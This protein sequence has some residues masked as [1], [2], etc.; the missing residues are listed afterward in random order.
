MPSVEKKGPVKLDVDSRSDR[1]R[2]G[3]LFWSAAADFAEAYAHEYNDQLGQ[4]GHEECFP[5]SRGKGEDDFVF[6][7][8]N[9]HFIGLSQ[10]D[11]DEKSNIKS[12][13][14]AVGREVCL[15]GRSMDSAV[16]AFGKLPENLKFA[17][18]DYTTDE[19]H[20]D[21]LKSEGLSGVKSAD[22]SDYMPPGTSR[23]ER[24]TVGELIERLENDLPED[25]KQGLE[26]REANHR[27]DYGNDMVFLH[28]MIDAVYRECLDGTTSGM[29]AALRV[30]SQT[31]FD[32][33]FAG[34]YVAG[35]LQDL[36]VQRGAEDKFAVFAEHCDK[37]MNE[38][39][40]GKLEEAVKNVF[41]KITGSEGVTVAPSPHGNP[42]GSGLAGEKLEKIG[43]VKLED[44]Y[45]KAI[46]IKASDLVSEH[47]SIAI[48]AS[49]FKGKE[50]DDAEFQKSNEKFLNDKVGMSGLENYVSHAAFEV[51]V[52]GRYLDSAV[53]AFS[54]LPKSCKQDIVYYVSKDSTVLFQAAVEKIASVST[55]RDAK[56]RG[57]NW[58]PDASIMRFNNQS[59]SADMLKAGKDVE[60]R[61]EAMAAYI[62]HFGVDVGVSGC[63]LKSAASV[64]SDLPQD[65]KKEVTDFLKT[66]ILKLDNKYFV[67]DP[68]PQRGGKD[69]T[70]ENI[71]TAKIPKGAF[72]IPGSLP[73]LTDVRGAAAGEA[74]KKDMA[75][76]AVVAEDWGESWRN[77]IATDIAVMGY[78]NEKNMMSHDKAGKDGFSVEDVP[79]VLGENPEC[80]RQVFG[81]GGSVAVMEQRPERN[82]E[83]DLNGKPE[84]FLIKTA[85]GAS[86][87]TED[88][89]VGKHENLSC[90]VKL[91]AIYENGELKMDKD[92]KVV[93]EGKLENGR[94]VRVTIEVESGIEKFAKPDDAIKRAKEVLADDLYKSVALGKH[95]ELLQAKE[96]VAKAAE[97]GKA[98]NT[99]KNDITD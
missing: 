34:S 35:E 96:N 77:K 44:I 83:I 9:N 81:A 16:E 25:W 98:D 84:Y 49:K 86:G 10:V 4:E 41:E 14:E 76:S 28:H 39:S 61:K 24:D 12:Y 63:S 85:F 93:F 18:M 29:D 74:L 26:S 38:L 22:T 6:K 30:L 1:E 21:V 94:Q 31:S 20:L 87:K 15:H 58:E 2:E 23:R 52:H 3:E 36:C 19:Y 67:A 92:N 71:L 54:K 89:F 68:F 62:K 57:G 95:P 90:D 75:V 27:E 11:S 13:L 56:G 5:K 55:L 47:G 79:G 17:V 97:A 45:R 50:F 91:P 88:T 48:S 65:L 82:G 37:K 69:Y 53:E 60:Q 64:F 66:E 80:I 7:M 78:L 32:A 59:L 99:P 51:G 42:S 43:L 40:G 46:E 33:D 72:D 70:L 8:N 73:A